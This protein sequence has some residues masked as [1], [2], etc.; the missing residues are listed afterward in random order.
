[1]MNENYIYSFKHDMDGPRSHLL[2]QDSQR[3]VA[4]VTISAFTFLLHSSNMMKKYARPAL[5]S[6]G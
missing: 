5:M 4:G 1:M 2:A 3:D 6:Y